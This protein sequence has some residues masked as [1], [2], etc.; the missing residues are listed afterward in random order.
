[1]EQGVGVTF[2]VELI[3]QSGEHTILGHVEM[4]AAAA[5][6]VPMVV[7]VITTITTTSTTTTTTT[8]T[9]TTI[10][11]TA[12]SHIHAQMGL[13]NPLSKPLFGGK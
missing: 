8:T 2:F 7:V 9:R 10:A 12:I 5:V 11:T 4:I 13:H 6:L 3:Q 1:M